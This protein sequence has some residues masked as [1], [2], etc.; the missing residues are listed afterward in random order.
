MTQFRIFFILILLSG[1]AAC[2]KPDIFL[3][4][5]EA[6]LIQSPGTVQD[7]L[8]NLVCVHPEKM[9]VFPGEEI[10]FMQFA[11]RYVRYTPACSEIIGLTVF[12]FVVEPDGSTSNLKIL[13]LPHPCLEPMIREMFAQMPRWAP[14]ELNGYPVRIQMVCPLRLCAR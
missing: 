11:T 12:S 1:I 9:P 7:S 13:K 4:V 8:Q 6:T 3:P 10:A 5:D 2:R 14:G